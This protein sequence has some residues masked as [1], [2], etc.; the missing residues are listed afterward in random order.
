MVFQLSAVNI[1]QNT[2]I[3][4]RKTILFSFFFISVVLIWIII[5]VLEIFL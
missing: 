4:R 3:Q 5:A 2:D 1:T